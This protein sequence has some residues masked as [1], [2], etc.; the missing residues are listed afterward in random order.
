MHAINSNSTIQLLYVGV[1]SYE[2][3]RFWTMESFGIGP[4]LSERKLLSSSHIFSNFSKCIQNIGNRYQVPLVFKKDKSPDLIVNNKSIALKR[5]EQTYKMLDKDPNLKDQY[6]NVFLTYEKEDMIEDVPK[7][8][9]ENLP[10]QPY[11]L[12]HRPVIKLS[13][14]STKIRPVFDGSCKSFNGLS[15]NDLLDEGPSMNP[16]IVSILLRFRRWLVALMADIK[17]AFLQEALHPYFRDLCC[18]LLKLRHC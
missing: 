11:Y 5:L 17:M 4:V 18:F 8:A 2:T 1:S 15:I 14:V 7:D 3:D 16:S 9:D 13:K 12:P 6:H 10:Y